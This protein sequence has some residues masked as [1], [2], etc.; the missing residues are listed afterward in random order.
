[1]KVWWTFTV[2][3]ME[4]HK[5]TDGLT[6]TDYLTDVYKETDK[7][8]IDVYIEAGRRPHVFL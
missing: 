1:M 8:R 3:S 4:I 5:E 6:S 7:K 2:V